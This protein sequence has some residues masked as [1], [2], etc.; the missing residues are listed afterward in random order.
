MFS[1]KIST[2]RAVS[3]DG[4][5]TTCPNCGGGD[6]EDNRIDE[7]LYREAAREAPRLRYEGCT[8]EAM[9]VLIA[10]YAI[11]IANFLRPEWLCLSCGVTF[12][13]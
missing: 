4:P 8:D 11:R 5:V 7:A 12:D 9:E 2:S 13:G 6:Y 1:A 3:D 10:L